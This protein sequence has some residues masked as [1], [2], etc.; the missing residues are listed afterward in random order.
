MYCAAVVLSFVIHLLVLVLFSQSRAVEISKFSWP[1]GLN[2]G[3]SNRSQYL[4]LLY[5]YKTWQ[6][7]W[8]EDIWV[9]LE[10]NFILKDLNFQKQQQQQQQKMCK[11]KNNVALYF[12][13]S[14]KCKNP[15]YANLPCCL[16]LNDYEVSK[17][18]RTKFCG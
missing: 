17:G 13:P 18:R 7:K 16:K 2:H 11:S 9:V 3:N 15:V 6:V 10:L 4:S 12:E 1:L 8:D 5:L 14:W